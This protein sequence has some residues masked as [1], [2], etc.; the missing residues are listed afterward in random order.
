MNYQCGSILSGR[1]SMENDQSFQ[2]GQGVTPG[3][4][5]PQFAQQ[6]Q[7]QQFVQQP[8]QP[9]PQS[10]DQQP[11]QQAQPVYQQPVQQP[12]P[13]PVQQEQPVYQQP[14]QQPVPQP[15]QQQIAPV[16]PVLQQPRLVNGKNCAYCGTLNVA[17]A[18]YCYNC[19]NYIDPSYAA[20]TCQTCHTLN[21]PGVAYCVKCGS[22]L[23]AGRQAMPAQQGAV[24]GYNPA[25]TPDT[26]ESSY[27]G[28][29]VS[30]FLHLLVVFLFSSLTLFLA[31]PAL[32]CWYF[33]WETSH[34]RINGRQLEFD[35]KGIQLFGKLVLWSFLTIITVGLYGIFRM[36]LNLQRWRTSHTHV[37]GYRT[38]DGNK[39]ES[40]FDGSIFGLW[41]VYLARAICLPLSFITLGFLGIAAKRYK[42]AW[43]AKHKIYDGQMMQFDGTTVQLWGK[44][45]LWFLLT[46]ITI[47]IYTAWMLNNI[48]K[49]SYKHTKFNA[50]GMFPAPATEMQPLGR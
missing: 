13:Q 8:Q 9:A 12:V 42:Y 27:D 40:K 34:V 23:A 35:G 28:G 26:Y 21:A 1:M 43:F 30:N 6:P 17:D 44:T 25:E 3:Q 46:F 20:R 36:P 18:V 14:V 22:T 45:I 37:A 41:G 32:V 29:A 15:V 10:V 4:E 2:N 31:M 24:M 11:V 48:K 16:Q 7:Q 33:R 19:G 49:W 38:P 39:G 5:A 50:P 47:G